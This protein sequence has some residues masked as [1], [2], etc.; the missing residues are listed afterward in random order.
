VLFLLVLLL[1]FDRLRE[2]FGVYD[3]LSAEPSA[4]FDLASTFDD[5]FL[6]L[7]DSFTIE[8]FVDFCS[9]D[10]AAGVND[11]VLSNREDLAALLE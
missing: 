3:V 11:L 2:V 6:V 7:D 4:D 9:N 1:N 8:L 5:I 10:L